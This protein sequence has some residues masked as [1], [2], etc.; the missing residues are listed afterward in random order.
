[1]YE[2]EEVME[3]AME[4]GLDDTFSGGNILAMR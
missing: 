1:M 3:Y 4:I 2:W